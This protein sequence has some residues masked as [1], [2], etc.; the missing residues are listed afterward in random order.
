MNVAGVDDDGST[1]LGGVS[2]KIGGMTAFAC[3]DDSV[4]PVMCIEGNGDADSSGVISK[5]IP[6]PEG[7]TM[8][9][10]VGLDALLI[11]RLVGEGDLLSDIRLVSKDKPS[12][13]PSLSSVTVEGSF[14][15][16]FLL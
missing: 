14:R 7:K 2:T 15:P 12:S 11:G 6:G 9:G 5:R 16:V 1:S 13:L 3:E 8:E 4:E 10:I